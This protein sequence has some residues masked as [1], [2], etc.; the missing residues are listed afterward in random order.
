MKT[1]TRV[2]MFKDGMKVVNRTQGV[3][4]RAHEVGGGSAKGW[5]WT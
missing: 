2:E 1:V 5:A 3:I 4:N